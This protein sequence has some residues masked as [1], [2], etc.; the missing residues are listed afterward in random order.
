ME[1]EITMSKVKTFKDM[2]S[3]EI[4]WKEGS[5]V[6]SYSSTGVVKLKDVAKK[7]SKTFGKP[8]AYSHVGIWKY[9]NLLDRGASKLKQGHQL[10]V[11]GWRFLQASN[12]IR[13]K[14]HLSN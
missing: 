5:N 11:V 2:I 3:L 13:F 12:L 4:P 10:W 8:R 1:E 7:G 6:W 9:K 14:I